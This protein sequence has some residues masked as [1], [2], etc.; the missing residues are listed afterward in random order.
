[1]LSTFAIKL[2]FLFGVFLHFIT[3]A[4][5][6]YMQILLY[7]DFSIEQLQKAQKF[8]KAT[9]SKLNKQVKNTY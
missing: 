3:G 6:F 7:R 1:M 8:I 2:H 5:I 4:D 9:I